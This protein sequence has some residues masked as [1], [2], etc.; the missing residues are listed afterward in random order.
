VAYRPAPSS[1][2]VGSSFVLQSIPASGALCIA[3]SE[4]WKRSAIRSRALWLHCGYLDHRSCIAENEYGILHSIRILFIRW[5]WYNS[6]NCAQLKRA[7]EQLG[8]RVC[9]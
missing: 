6:P 1:N 9:L 4:K 2:L 5:C 8:K 7:R 3:C